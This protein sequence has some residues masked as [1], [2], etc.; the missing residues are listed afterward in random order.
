MP[1]VGQSVVFKVILKQNKLYEK[2]LA[3][4]YIVNVFFHFEQKKV[5]LTVRPYVCQ[6][7][8]SKT[9][10]AKWDAFAIPKFCIY[11]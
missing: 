2:N 7:D 4:F 1:V 5:Q 10:L 6:R 3:I 11:T 8:N 9:Q